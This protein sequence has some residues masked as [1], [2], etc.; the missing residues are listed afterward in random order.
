MLQWMDGSG[1]QEHCKSGSQTAPEWLLLSHPRH[2]HGD[3]TS[4]AP[5]E[6]LPEILVV[7][8]EKTPTG[9]ASGP[10]SQHRLRIRA[11]LISTPGQALCQV[12]KLH[13]CPPS[14]TS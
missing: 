6:R 9:A 11:M 7:P 3:L 4:L 8:R 12:P 14:F 2:A 5:H 10:S 13:Q 1:T